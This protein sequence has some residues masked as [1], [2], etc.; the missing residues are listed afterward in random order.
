MNVLQIK[1]SHWRT[2]VTYILELDDLGSVF[3]LIRELKP[4]NKKNLLHI[5]DTLGA[6][7]PFIRYPLPPL[8]TP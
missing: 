7:A 1:Y 5:P 2:Y 6:R 8:V 4:C 3:L